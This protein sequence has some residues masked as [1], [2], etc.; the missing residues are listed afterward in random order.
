MLTGRGAAPERDGAVAW[1]EPPALLSVPSPFPRRRTHQHGQ[2]TKTPI[3]PQPEEVPR[4][5]FLQTDS[6]GP[7]VCHSSVFLL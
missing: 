5:L 3:L 2:L 7:R 1:R 6:G 4:D